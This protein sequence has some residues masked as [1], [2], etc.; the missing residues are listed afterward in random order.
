MGQHIFEAACFI[1]KHFVAFGKQIAKFIKRNLTPHKFVYAIKQFNMAINSYKKHLGWMT[2][3]DLLAHVVNDT[4]IVPD[5]V[6]S[7]LSGDHMKALLHDNFPDYVSDICFVKF[8][9][10]YVYDKACSLRVVY[11]DVITTCESHGQQNYGEIEEQFCRLYN[12]KQCTI[13]EFT[14]SA[15]RE[16]AEDTVG[17]L[18]AYEQHCALPENKYRDLMIASCAIDTQNIKT[19]ITVAPGEE[20]DEVSCKNFAQA[21]DQCHDDSQDYRFMQPERDTSIL[22]SYTRFSIKLVIFTTNTHNGVSSLNICIYRS[23][24]NRTLSC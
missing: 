20:L 23:S 18:T 12:L 14:L 4:Q 13:K 16:I 19:Y 7:V 1:Q 15:I 21:I 2:P 10:K 6:K 9:V 8:F 24:N 17:L 3:D 22:F 11:R 5:N